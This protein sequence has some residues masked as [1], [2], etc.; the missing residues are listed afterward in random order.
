MKRSDAKSFNKEKFVF[1]IATGVFCAALFLFLAYGPATL[2]PGKP[3]GT[4]QG[5]VALNN[6]KFRTFQE[7]S[8]QIKLDS[9]R[10]NPFA[11]AAGYNE[12]KPVTPNPSILPVPAPPPPPPPAP[13]TPEPK[14]KNFD[15][16]D[17][18]AEVSFMGVVMMNGDTYGLLKPND[19]S[20]PR[21]VKVGDTLPDLKY[22]VTRIEKQAIY[23]T[24]E[25]D[26]PFVISDGTFGDEVAQADDSTP[27]KKAAHTPAPKH[28]QP[29]K[30]PPVK[31]APQ[32]EKTA[33][34]EKEPRTPRKKPGM[35]PNTNKRNP[36]TEKQAR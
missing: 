11:P 17:A 1:L 4:Q 2:E 22:T 7:T 12:A 18:K 16:E 30:Q 14:K 34:K 35:T 21:R 33:P 9:Q 6:E 31:V 5:P 27:P 3:M 15:A 8:S 13:V 29:E 24:D 19:G 36:R 10:K 26:R 25:E 20:S 32:P 23:V 28:V